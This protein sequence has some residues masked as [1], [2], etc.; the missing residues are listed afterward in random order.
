MDPATV[1][2][3]VREIEGKDLSTAAHTWRVVLYTR[4]LL[5]HFGVERD[6]IALLTQAAALH[7]VGKIDIPDAVLQ[8]PGRLTDEEFEIIK[9][10]PVTGYARMIDLDVQE[11][12]ILNF[13]RYHHE[14]WDGLGYPFQLKGEEIPLGPRVFAV[15]DSFDAMTSVRP[16]R[17]ELG[18]RAAERAIVELQAGIG[19]RYWADGVEAFADLYHTGKLDHILHYFNDE[20]TVPA[21][22]QARDDQFEDIRQRHTPPEPPPS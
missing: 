9:L 12:P 8:K 4:A 2:R 21:F 18:E 15:I 17:R 5:E 7:D 20:V 11:E 3:L 10:H 13:V 14:R 1:Q 16:Y 22:E 19:T 6:L